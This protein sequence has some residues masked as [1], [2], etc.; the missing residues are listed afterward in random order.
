MPCAVASWPVTGMASSLRDLSAETTEL[1]RPS[2]AAS[3]PSILLP[4]F[5]SICSKIVSA[6]WLSQ[7]GTDWFGPFLSLPDGVERIE[8]G[9]VALREQRRVVVVGRAV[10]LG[11]RRL[12]PEA[13]ARQSTRPWPW[14]LPTFTLSKET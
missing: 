8:H 3:T 9:V 5:C 7:S 10:E 11:D 4:V 1:P 13:S 12:V 6:F 2:L 14:S